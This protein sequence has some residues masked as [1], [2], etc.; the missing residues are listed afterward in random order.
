MAA[1]RSSDFC[2]PALDVLAREATLRVPSSHGGA[3]GVLWR[4]QLWTQTRGELGQNSVL[5][6]P[7]PMRAMPLSSRVSPG[8]TRRCR[9][10]VVNYP[11]G[12]QPPQAVG[13]HELQRLCCRVDGEQKARDQ[14]LGGT[15]NRTALN[16]PVARPPAIAAGSPPSIGDGKMVAARKGGRECRRS[17]QSGSE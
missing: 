1:C 16:W 3:P 15:V 10:E 6:T 4:T 12:L 14:C 7:A 13:G 5:A 9:R 8:L 11:I 17:G 2:Q